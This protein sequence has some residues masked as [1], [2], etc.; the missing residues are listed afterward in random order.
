MLKKLQ[1]NKH[2]CLSCALKVGLVVKKTPVKITVN[3]C[4]NCKCSK[5]GLTLNEYS[6][7]EDK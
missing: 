4:Q 1:K 2:I 7:D 6:N 5:N 3:K